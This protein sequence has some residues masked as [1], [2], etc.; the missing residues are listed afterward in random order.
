MAP[1]MVEPLVSKVPDGIKMGLVARRTFPME[2][3]TSPRMKGSPNR[4]RKMPSRNQHVLVCGLGRWK[5]P[6]LIAS[7]MARKRGSK[8]IYQKINKLKSSTFG[9]CFDNFTPGN[10]RKIS[11]DKGYAVNDLVSAQPL[12]QKVRPK[13]S[14]SD[15]KMT[16]SVEHCSAAIIYE[17][18]NVRIFKIPTQLVLPRIFYNSRGDKEY[19]PG[20]SLENK[21]ILVMKFDSLGDGIAFY[22]K[23]AKE[24]GFKVH[25][26]T[27]KVDKN[28]VGSSNGKGVTV[29]KYLLCSKEGSIRE[30]PDLYIMNRWRKD[31]LKK[32]SA[33]N[34]VL[35]M[36]LSMIRRSNW[37]LSSFEEQ[38]L[39]KTNLKMQLVQ[40]R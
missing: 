14:L 17:D 19:I 20:C 24:C 1:R 6:R 11:V 29:I 5:T 26:S 30:I 23:Y 31:I 9:R 33:M 27:T 28:K 32:A 18:M 12:L 3:M 22:Y 13:R 38:M 4:V 2:A 25:S 8:K 40:K 39:T 37:T 35:M 36:L 21:P 10:K 15:R 16:E 34:A 7:L